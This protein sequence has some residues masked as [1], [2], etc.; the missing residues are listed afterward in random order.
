MFFMTVLANLPATLQLIGAGLI[1]VVSV[2][3]AAGVHWALSPAA[4]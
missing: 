1:A 4:R 2:A 3:V